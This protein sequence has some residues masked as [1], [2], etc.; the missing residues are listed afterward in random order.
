[1]SSCVSRPLREES[2]F[3]E[4]SIRRRE[5]EL[6]R[7]SSESMALWVMYNSFRFGRVE[8]W[9]REGEVMRLDWTERRVRFCN[10]ERFCSGF[11]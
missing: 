1:M 3:E 4:T 5:C 9:A 2:G 11:S 10:E 8:R 7:G 6:E